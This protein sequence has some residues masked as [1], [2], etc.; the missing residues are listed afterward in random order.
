MP[1]TKASSTFITNQPLILWSSEKEGGTIYALTTKGKAHEPASAQ[2]VIED[3]DHLGVFQRGQLVIEVK[4]MRGNRAKATIA[5][6]TLC[7]GDFAL[8]QVEE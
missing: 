1:K 5:G 4:L 7:T 6:L 2:I 3:W 8:D